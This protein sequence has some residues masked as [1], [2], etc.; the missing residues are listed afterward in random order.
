MQTRQMYLIFR[1][2]FLKSRSFVVSFIAKHLELH[3]RE[4]SHKIMIV[5]NGNYEN[6]CIEAKKKNFFH[7]TLSF[8][9]FKLQLQKI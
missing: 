1:N 2:S 4:C 3:Y 5:E 6:G 9:L 8:V 7:P